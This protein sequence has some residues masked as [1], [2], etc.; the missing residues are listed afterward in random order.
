MKNMMKN[1]NFPSIEEFISAIGRDSDS[2]ELQLIFS[3]IGIKIKNLDDYRLDVKGQRLWSDDSAGLQL[4]FKDIGILREIP[5]HD[6]DEGPW[7]LTDVIFW[8]WREKTNSCY[9]GAL[10]YGLDFSMSRASVREKIS[11]ELGQPEILG[12]SDNID[13][14]VLGTMKIAIDYAG[15]KGIRCISLGMP[16]EE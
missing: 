9:T 6:I 7:V 13:M 1:M 4:E 2:S 10:P 3:K 14:W 16:V 11:R 15:K 8:G 5:Y 12:F